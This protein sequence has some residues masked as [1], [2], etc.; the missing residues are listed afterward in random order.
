MNNSKNIIILVIMISLFFL[1]DV[2]GQEIMQSPQEIDTPLQIWDTTS[3]FIIKTETID[4]NGDNKLDY[5]VL[6]RNPSWHS[7]STEPFAFEFWYSSSF[8]V[9][10]KVPKYIVDYDYRWFINLDKDPEPEIISALGY[11][12]GITYAIYDQNPKNWAEPLI[13]SFNPILFDLSNRS[14]EYYWGYAWDIK[15]IMTRTHRG[16]IQIRC[17]FDHEIYR[18]GEHYVPDW[19]QQNRLPVIFFVGKSKKRY[20]KDY[21]IGKLQWLSFQE[22]IEK[23]KR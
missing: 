16:M 12:D 18:D 19:Q 13:L 21:R 6:F 3:E 11:S 20:T 1:V 23:A 15:N 5:I 2:S 14:K 4:F 9:V 8:K 10:K 22:I 7:S 17:S